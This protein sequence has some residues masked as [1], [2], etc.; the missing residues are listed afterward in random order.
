MSTPL[1]TYLHDHFAGSK[2]AVDLLGVLRDEHAGEPLA[3]TAAQ[4]LAEVEEDRTVLA[5]LVERAGSPAAGLVKEGMA[6]IGEQGTR[7]KLRTRA[8]DGA[9]T[10]ELLETLALGILGKLSLWR[11]LAQIDPADPIVANIDLA[12]LMERAEQQHAMVEE[13]R[14]AAAR[15]LFNARAA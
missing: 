8:S 2:V 13:R 12:L 4:L 7:L 15:Q 10:L 6:W 5:R 9:G 14:L 11:A 1:A 3:R